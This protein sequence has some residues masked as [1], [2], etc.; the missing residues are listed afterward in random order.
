[1]TLAARTV[2]ILTCAGISPT[3]AEQAAE[4]EEI[5][6]L[7]AIAI[8]SSDGSL[9]GKDSTEQVLVSGWLS[10][11][12]KTLD[13]VHLEA[14]DKQLLS[15]SYLASNRATLAD[16]A[17]FIAVAEQYDSV[18]F[19]TYQCIG[20]WY[21]HINYL[22][23]R[24]SAAT[25]GLGLPAVVVSNTPTW[26]PSLVDDAS[27]N[28]TP[29]TVPSSS[30]A[31]SGSAGE[32]GKAQSAESNGVTKKENKKSNKTPS[33][34]AGAGKS[35]KGTSGNAAPATAAAGLDPSKLDI[36]CGLVVKCWDHPESDKLLC[37]E[38]DLGE[39]SHRTIASGLRAH[40][41]AEEVQG[42]KVVVLAN[43]KERPMAGFKSQ[44]MVLC[45]VNSD[46]S[47]VR[48][49]EPPAAASVGDKVSFPGFEGEPATPAQVAKKKLLEGLAPMLR[50]D[51]S[52]VA[53]WDQSAF[54]IAGAVCTAPLPDATVS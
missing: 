17:V 25:A 16:F 42:R 14:L 32:G 3:N 44:G 21:K 38:I 26:I 43:L 15:R 41:K 46:H 22:S 47:V 53:H 40:Y 35:E 31:A 33:A 23:S 2:K 13:A 39:G 45:A 11:S 7:K 8:A 27:S 10:F 12:A 48:L 51:G 1:M 20:R 6:K 52:G 19:E 18:S 50:T 5:T 29:P 4:V 54:T 24:N 30:A 36:R 28:G 49:L 9:L 34:D 37:E